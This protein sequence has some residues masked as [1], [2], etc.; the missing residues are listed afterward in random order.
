MKRIDQ[1]GSVALHHDKTTGW[2][3]VAA[4]SY[5]SK[6]YNLVTEA[7]VE[8]IC[9]EVNLLEGDVDNVAT[10]ISEIFQEKYPITLLNAAIKREWK[11]Y[12]GSCSN[13]SNLGLLSKHRISSYGI[14]NQSLLFDIAIK[15]IE[16]FDVKELRTSA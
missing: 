4:E 16:E 5:W 11:S 7:S 10:K 13:L 1:K 15:E 12:Q 6:I 3:V 14:K 2:R 9:A 8:D